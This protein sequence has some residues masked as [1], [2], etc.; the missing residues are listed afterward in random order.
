M[1]YTLKLGPNGQYILDTQ[2]LFATTYAPRIGTAEFEAY[3][4]QKTTTT[5]TSQG[6]AGQTTLA[7]QTEKVMRETPGQ[8]QTVTDPVTGETK[9][10]TK[11]QAITEIK[12]TISTL[13][14][15]TTGTGPKETSLDKVQKILA[16]TPA[17]TGGISGSD[18]LKQIEAIQKSAQKAQLVNT[19]VKGGLDIGVNYLKQSMGGFQTGGYTGPMTQLMGGSYGAGGGYVPVGYE[20]FGAGGEFATG[21]GGGGFGGAGLAAATTFMQTGDI[22]K[23]AG[24]GAGAYA[25]QAIGTAIGGPIGGAIGATIGGA[26]GGCFLPDTLV[27]MSN[28]STKKIIDIDLKDNI[29]IGGRVFATGKFLV[30]NLYNYKGV[31]VSGSHLVNENNKWLRVEDSKISIPLGNDEHIVYTLGTDNRRILIN[32]ILFTDYFEVEDQ[33]N[34][35][36]DGDSYFTNWQH[37]TKNLSNKNINILNKFI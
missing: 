21:G 10:V 15:P 37:Y 33:N 22:G 2:D 29:A 3:T 18:Y 24:A 14:T 30:N 19:L 20:G 1:A 16:A 23:A 9:T 8:Y 28:G 7:Q 32:N 34:L 35:L 27:T 12:D 13:P 5:P 6:L 36:K 4:G 17:Q 31:K 26:I 25:G 11:G